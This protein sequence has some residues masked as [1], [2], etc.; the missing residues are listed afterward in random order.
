VAAETEL[1][2]PVK[3]ELHAAGA[4]PR[5]VGTVPPDSRL[6]VN[7]HGCFASLNIADEVADK[8]TVVPVLLM[9]AEVA[10]LLQ[11]GVV[12]GGGNSGTGPWLDEVAVRTPAHGIPVEDDAGHAITANSKPQLGAVG[13]V[14]IANG[15]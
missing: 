15:I 4:T 1:L 6:E 3:L 10:G 2:D 13:T 9:A 12:E 14:P 8:V 7:P 5:A 11:V